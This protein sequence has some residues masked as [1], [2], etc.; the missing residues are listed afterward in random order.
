MTR[1]YR[2][3]QGVKNRSTSP[4]PRSRNV[5][6]PTQDPTAPSTTVQVR[7]CTHETPVNDHTVRRWL[8]AIAGLICILSLSFG[9]ATGRWTLNLFQEPDP[10]YGDGFVA[11]GFADDSKI[12]VRIQESIFSTDGHD[13]VTYTIGFPEEARGKR[14]AILLTGDATLSG[15][16]TFATA[17]PEWSPAI[18]HLECPNIPNGCQLIE[19]QVANDAHA[20]DIVNYDPSCATG[21]ATPAAIETVGVSGVAHLTKTRAGSRKS[22]PLLQDPPG[23][24]E[25]LNH[26]LNS[27]VQ[28]IGDI[29][30]E[31]ADIITCKEVQ[32]SPDLEV[33]SA[34]PAPQFTGNGDLAWVTAT[35]ATDDIGNDNQVLTL[36]PTN[37]ASRQNRGI[38]IVGIEF[39]LLCGFLPV[40]VE[41]CIYELLARIRRGAPR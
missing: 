10:I 4:P 22:V 33:G 14:W 27:T 5:V 7:P 17:P 19:G 6:R 25:Q 28:G 15:P 2:S 36:R 29:Y 38:V 39:A 12:P 23:A 37:L 18:T 40:L 11:V 13:R 21:L 30:R 24:G 34:A 35:K 32:Y 20:S 41:C 31:S 16:N 1:R 3:R 26:V 8:G 9:I